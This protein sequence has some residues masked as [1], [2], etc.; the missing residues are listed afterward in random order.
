[1]NITLIAVDKLRE[2]YLRVGCARIGARLRPYMSVDIVEIKPQG[3][4]AEAASMLSRVADGSVIWA[5]DREGELLDS[6][7]VAQRL[8]GVER[9][10]ARR[11]T[12]LIGGPDGLHQ[13]A[14]ARADLRWSLSPLTFLHEMARLIVLE[15][16]Y[17]AVKINR[18]EPYHR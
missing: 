14:M 17:R 4:Q 3:P 7:Q 5:L 18:G 13:S 9:T 10:G 15:Q 8:A 1:M 11:L 16:L 2:P 12:L 6:P